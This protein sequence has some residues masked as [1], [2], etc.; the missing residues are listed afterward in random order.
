MKI[1]PIAL[2]IILR[3]KIGRKLDISDMDAVLA[4]FQVVGTLP[5]TKEK[6]A[7]LHTGFDNEL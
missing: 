3:C 5:C 2:P 1:V 4:S 6:I 7:G